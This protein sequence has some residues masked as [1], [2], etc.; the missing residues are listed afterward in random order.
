MYGPTGVGFL[1][2]RPEIL[3]AKLQS[4]QVFADVCN[5]AECNV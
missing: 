1:W 2:G 3:E 4:P 5:V